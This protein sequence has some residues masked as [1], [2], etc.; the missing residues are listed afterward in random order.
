MQRSEAFDALLGTDTKLPI[1]RFGSPGAFL[2]LPAACGLDP[3]GRTEVVLLPGA[4]IPEGCTEGDLIHVLITLDSEDRPLATCTEPKLY[5]GEVAFLEVTSLTAFG[6]FVDWGLPKELLVPLGEQTRD[7]RVGE[8]HPISLYVDPSGRLA[9]TM[10][11][12]EV[13]EPLRDVEEDQWVWGEAWRNEP[14]LGIFVIVDRKY[15]GLVPE[16]EPTSLGR[17]D[18]AEF[19]VSNILHDGKVELSLRGPAHKEQGGDAARLLA[20]LQQE[21]AEPLS[22]KSD[23]EQVRR[24]LNLSKKALKKAAGHLLRSRVIDLGHQGRYVIR[25]KS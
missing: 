16:H 24:C 8:R 23:P 22:D 4:E 18:A 21:D 11:I 13:L 3:Q 5:R 25:T 10:K 9:G 20:Y 12:R 2:E 17:G 6:A 14:G 19:R 15:L 7:L 1:V